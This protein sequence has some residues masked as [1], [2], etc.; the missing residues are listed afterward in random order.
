M[1]IKGKI[2]AIEQ[3]KVISDK[4]SIQEFV[5]ETQ[6]QYPKKLALQAINKCQFDLVRMGIG[7]CGTFT[8]IATVASPF[9]PV[10]SVA[11]TVIV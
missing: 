3:V 1:E 8:L 10:L 5:I 6:G 11:T 2:L 7:A 4:F 9:L